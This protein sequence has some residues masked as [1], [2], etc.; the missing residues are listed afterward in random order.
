MIDYIRK[1]NFRGIEKGAAYYKKGKWM[2]GT[3]NAKHATKT[4]I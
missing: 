1:K 4:V 3:E 2:N